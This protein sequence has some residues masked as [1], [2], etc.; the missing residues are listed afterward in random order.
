MAFETTITDIA[1]ADPETGLAWSAPELQFSAPAWAPTAI[2]AQVPGT[3]TVSSPLERIEINSDEMLASLSLEPGPD[4]TLIASEVSMRGV[5]LAST[6]DWTAALTSGVL[7]SQRAGSD[8]L[9]HDIKFETRDF[10]PSGSVLLN[11][12]PSGTLP[13]LRHNG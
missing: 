2:E 13:V 5:T 6:A 11:L 4:L 8:S 10:Q 3:Q 9:A 7:A 12:D 1:L